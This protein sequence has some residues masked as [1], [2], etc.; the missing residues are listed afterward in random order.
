[1]VSVQDD[2]SLLKQDESSRPQLVMDGDGDRLHK[3]SANNPTNSRPTFHR[4]FLDVADISPTEKL[5][6]LS[7]SELLNGMS[8]VASCTNLSPIIEQKT[9]L[10]TSDSKSAR[11]LVKEESDCE[12]SKLDERTQCEDD[13]HEVRDEDA[14]RDRR[15]NA[16]L[17]LISLADV[18]S[19]VAEDQLVSSTENDSGNSST[20]TTTVTTTITTTAA[21]AAAATTKLLALSDSFPLELNALRLLCTV[22][23]VTVRIKLIFIFCL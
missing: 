15:L 4:P 12:L 17:G 3:K 2:S 1:M 18:S 7:G 16:A 19:D 21:A 11:N 8:A 9:D 13:R 22:T 14:G 5:Y 10:C 20:T 23:E 6:K